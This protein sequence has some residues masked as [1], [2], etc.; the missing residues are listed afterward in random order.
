MCPLIDR[1]VPLSFEKRNENGP[2]KARRTKPPTCKGGGG[3][4]AA[5]RTGYYIQQGQ[6]GQVEK[7]HGRI[8]EKV[9]PEVPICVRYL[10]REVSSRIKGF[11]SGLRTNTVFSLL[12]QKCCAYYFN[13]SPFAHINTPTHVR[14]ES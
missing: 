9:A 8:D 11:S 5:R 6:L 14:R 13:L 7:L 2:H 3:R 4:K 1:R 10:F 12:A